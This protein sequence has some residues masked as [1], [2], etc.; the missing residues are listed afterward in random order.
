MFGL[1][2]QLLCHHRWD[3][4]SSLPG[5]GAEGTARLCPGHCHFP[6]LF[7]T[8][9]PVVRVILIPNLCLLGGNDG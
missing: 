7:I 9:S 1:R 3:G 2:V 4:Q 8:S 5:D 6:Q